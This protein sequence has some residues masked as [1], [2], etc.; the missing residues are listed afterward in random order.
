MSSGTPSQGTRFGRTL[1]V[2]GAGEVI[3]QPVQ[4][5]VYPANQRGVMGAGPSGSIRT[6]G[7]ADVEREAM[8]HAPIDLGTAVMTGSGHL[9]ERGITAV[10]HAAVIPSIGESARLDAVERAVTATLRA[11]DRAK[12]KSV[13]MPLLGT[14]ADALDHDR[15]TAAEQIVDAA[16]AYLRREGSRLERIMV[17]SRFEDDVAMVNGVIQR[18]RERSWVS[19]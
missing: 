16:V 7:G 6:A 18:A 14:S 3:D 12:I 10:I 2:A 19:Q 17:I 8:A 1:L 11:A 13:A 4:A 15:E 9:E 5:V